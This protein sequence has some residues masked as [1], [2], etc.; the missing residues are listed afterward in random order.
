MR[1]I[2]N[3]SLPPVMAKKVKSAVKKGNYSSVSEFFRELLRDWQA[4]ILL[5]DVGESRY[6]I[7][8]GKDKTLKSLK[9]LR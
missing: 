4:G 5:R 8:A 6:Q 7:A 9:D 1:E 3:I 2:I